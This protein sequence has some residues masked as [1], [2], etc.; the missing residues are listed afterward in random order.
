MYSCYRSNLAVADQLSTDYE[1]AHNC[2][3]SRLGNEES[4]QK[5]AHLFKADLHVTLFLKIFGIAALVWGVL[6]GIGSCAISSSWGAF[7]GDY[8]EQE[9]KLL[10]PN[11]AFGIVMGSIIGLGVL[12]ILGDL[13]VFGIKNAKYRKQFEEDKKLIAK[14]N[15]SALVSYKNETNRQKIIVEKKL[16]RKNKYIDYSNISLNAY[17]KFISSG[18]LYK[19][20]QDIVPICQ[21][22]QYLES[23][24][25]D[26]LV[27]PHGCYNKYE[28]EIRQNTIITKLDYIY[29]SLQ[30]IE[31]NQQVIARTLKSIDESAR[32]IYNVA[33]NIEDKV[34]DIAD[35]VTAIKTCSAVSAAA[36]V[37][38]AAQ[39]RWISHRLE[40]FN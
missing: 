24:R 2:Y 21:F 37:Y 23:G 9:S 30:R 4:T 35:N 15:E 36:N 34:G 33:C 25:C 40:Y 20:Y 26:D 6:E 32:S 27:G 10:I 28:E 16:V 18:F 7:T 29:Q 17:K 14:Q 31:H 12:L 22:I 8:S 13:I 38:T 39:L 19:D 1:T 5:E 3:L 11:P